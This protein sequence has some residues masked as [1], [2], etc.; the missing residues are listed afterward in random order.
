MARETT[1]LSVTGMH[2]A[3]CEQRVTRALEQLPSVKVLRADH[4]EG[5]VEVR[6]NTARASLDEIRGRIEQMGYEVKP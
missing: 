4:Q 1:T 6:A 5:A 3:G 2:C